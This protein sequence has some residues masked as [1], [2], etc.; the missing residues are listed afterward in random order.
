MAKDLAV[1]G[2]QW[3]KEKSG[4]FRGTWEE[5]VGTVPQGKLT[6]VLKWEKSNGD[7]ESVRGKKLVGPGHYLDKLAGR[8]VI[9]RQKKKA[10]AKA[11][12]LLPQTV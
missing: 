6:E 9:P 11:R 7:R 10:E 4:L 2:V 5:G 12:G 3:G 1:K 8:R